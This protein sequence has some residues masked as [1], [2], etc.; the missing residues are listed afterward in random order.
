MTSSVLPLAGDVGAE[1]H[2]Q[3]GGWD[4]QQHTA[5]RFHIVRRLP[6][7][8]GISIFHGA[9]EHSAIVGGVL[10]FSCRTTILYRLNEIY[11]VL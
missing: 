1:S 9:S 8:Q 2:W 6:I 11:N 4:F 3:Q 5:A 7:I 10:T